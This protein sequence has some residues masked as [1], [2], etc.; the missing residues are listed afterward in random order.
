MCLWTTLIEKEKDKRIHSS[1]DVDNT[2]FLQDPVDPDT[3]DAM[4]TN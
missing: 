4:I 2:R 3:S 1:E